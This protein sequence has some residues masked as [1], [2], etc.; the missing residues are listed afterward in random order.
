M[1][2]K[3]LTVLNELGLHARVAC[4]ITRKANEFESSICIIKNG[5]TYDLKSVTGVI[6]TNAHQGDVVMLEINGPDEEKAA[7]AM[8]DLFFNKF[9][10]R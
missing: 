9:G 5:K 10:E 2:T 1:T 6:T 3:K 8:E 7:E 4:R